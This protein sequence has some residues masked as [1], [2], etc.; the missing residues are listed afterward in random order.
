MLRTLNYTGRIKINRTQAVFSINSQKEACPNFDVALSLDEDE[1]PS[2]AKVYIEAYYQQTQQRFDFGTISQ[3]KPP[4]NRDLNEIDL[5]GPTLFRVL[6]VDET[7]NHGLLLG[8]GSQF[9][10]KD[11]G[12][13]EHRTS[14][15]SVRSFDMGEVP[16][17]LNI[18]NNLEPELLLN[19]KLGNP[20][21]KIKSDAT[22][23]ALVLPS[24]LREILSYYLWNEEGIDDNDACRRWFT[25]AELLGDKKPTTDDPSDLTDWI[26]NVIREFC[27]Q[28]SLVG[29][30]FPESG[31]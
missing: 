16:W 9:K 18:A 20:I 29:S 21:E 5:S 1:F 10:A 14:L 7:G 4:V 19:S 30:L 26:N 24:V 22:F 2:D 23:Q 27:E 31:E 11:D 13:D 3:T 6:V 28:F 12:A 15:L 17:R 25:Y 8:S